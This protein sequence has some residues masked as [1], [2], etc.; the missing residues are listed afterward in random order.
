[1]AALWIQF[2]NFRLNLAQI[3]YIRRDGELLRFFNTDGTQFF[4]RQ[5]ESDVRARR[6]LDE[7]FKYEEV[8]VL[9]SH[10]EGSEPTSSD[11]DDAS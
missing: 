3:G 5:F 11:G 2:G 8:R 4:A 10:Y 9:R 1:M 7:L 6:V